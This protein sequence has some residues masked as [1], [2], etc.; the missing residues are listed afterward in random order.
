MEERPSDFPE[1]EVDEYFYLT[2][3]TFYYHFNLEDA[4]AFWLNTNKDVTRLM[5]EIEKIIKYEIVN[6][7]VLTNNRMNDFYN[8]D[9]TRSLV[10]V[11][12]ESD[13]EADKIRK[14]WIKTIKRSRWLKNLL[15]RVVNSDM[16]SEENKVRYDR[17]NSIIDVLPKNIKFL[18]TYPNMLP[19]IHFI[20]FLG[21]DDTVPTYGGGEFLVDS[22]LIILLF[23]SGQLS[24]WFN[25][26]NDTDPLDPKEIIYTYYYALANQT[27]ETYE[28]NKIADFSHEDFFEVVIEKIILSDKD[29][30]E[31][32]KTSLLKTISELENH[33]DTF[34]KACEEEETLQAHEA[35]AIASLGGDSDSMDQSLSWWYEAM[36]DPE[37]M[38]PRKILRHHLGFDELGDGSYVLHEGFNSRSDAIGNYIENLYSQEISKAFSTMRKGFAQK[39]ILVSTIMDVFK[40]FKGDSWPRID[41]IAKEQLQVYFGLQADYVKLYA[42]AESKIR[43]CDILFLKR[44]RNIRP[45]IDLSRDRR[46]KSSF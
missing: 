2:H 16:L 37:V 29:E 23:F 20:A 4:T 34:Q 25:F 31:S 33:S 42:E 36:R 39:K 35:E 15:T 11:F 13:K 45:S 12:L 30:M 18:V 3:Q 1:N 21:L 38:R 43:S 14:I 7:I 8:R 46:I 5:V 44:T 10:D 32:Q 26:G 24:P 17:I 40:N 19:L 27:F 22:K 28:T 6:N 9:V 41:E